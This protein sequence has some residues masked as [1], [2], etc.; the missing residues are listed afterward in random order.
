MIGRKIGFALAAAVLAAGALGCARASVKSN[1]STEYTKKLDR[2]LIV[3]PLDERMKEYEQLLHERMIAE[4][5]KRGVTSAFAKLTGGLD[6]KEAT[7]IDKQATDFDASTTLF[8]RRASG[9]VNSGGRLVNARFDAQLFDLAS[10]DRVWRA[11]IHY[12]LGDSLLTSDSQR[13]DALVGEL[14]KAL[15]NDGLL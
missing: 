13:V 7:P 4:L 1:K 6:L 2:T 12:N 15:A 3:F 9:T 10:K 11:S 8:I 5:Q 14:V